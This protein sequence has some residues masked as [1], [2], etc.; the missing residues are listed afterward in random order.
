MSPLAEG[1]SET[2]EITLDP[3]DDSAITG[4]L[5]ITTVNDPDEQ[6][7][8]VDLFG[9]EASAELEIE[10]SQLY[11]NDIPAG[12]SAE[13]Q[14]VVINPGRAT[15]DISTAIFSG[16]TEFSLDPDLAGVSI[17]AGDRFPVSVVY[18]RP[19]GDLTGFDNGLLTIQSNALPPNDTYT[20]NVYASH[21]AGALPPTAVIVATPD[22]PYAPD[23]EITLDAS[24]STPPDGPSGR[25]S[26]SVDTD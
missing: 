7:T 22:E 16:S 14:F 11:F 1:N 19:D 12:D 9:G 8:R 15:L 10:P 24:T 23:E 3:I 18:D 5:V 20:Y 4:Q 13:L 17:D 25:E 6:T 21:D 2:V 26:L